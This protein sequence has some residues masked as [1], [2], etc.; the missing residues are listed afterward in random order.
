MNTPPWIRSAASARAT[1]RIALSRAERSISAA[2]A[3]GRRAAA[4]ASAARGSARLMVLALGRVQPDTRRLSARGARPGCWPPE[5][6]RGKPEAARPAVALG[7]LG[8]SQW[9]LEAAREALGEV[10]VH[11]RPVVPRESVGDR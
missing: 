11:Q 4:L 10:Q 1:R 3:A 9:K 5:C 8:P 2:D 7:R 6:T